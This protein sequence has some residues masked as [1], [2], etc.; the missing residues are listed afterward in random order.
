MRT[1]AI[2]FT[3]LTALLLTNAALGQT[4]DAGDDRD[5]LRIVA[6]EALLS[7]PPERAL[8]RVK[9]VLEGDNSLEVKESALFILSQIDLPEAHALLIRI[10]RES[11]GDFQVEAIQMIGIGGDPEALGGLKEIFKSGDREVRE[12]VFDAYLIADDA[13][14]VYELALQSTA[15]EFATAVTILGSMGAND[16]LR[17]IH[18]NAGMSEDLIGAY[19]ISGAFET[20][21]DLALDSTDSQTQIQAIEALGILGEDKAG[22]TLVDVYRNSDSSEIRGAALDGMFIAGY[23]KGVLDLYQQSTDAKEKSELLEYLR[24]MDSDALWDVID[25]ALEGQR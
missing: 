8:P 18:E 9:K 15:E 7:A 13:E 16:Q 21:H 20:L 1:Y 4:S 25:A 12:A 19:M 6:L 11:S 24:I 10:A 17:R 23:D 2:L 22:V 14:S 3:T 5:Q